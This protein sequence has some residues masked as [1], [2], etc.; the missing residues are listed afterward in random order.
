[1][2]N[3]HTKLYVNVT[4]ST[5]TSCFR[6]VQIE[7]V[8]QQILLNYLISSLPHNILDWFKLEV[9]A[10]KKVS[11]SEEQKIVLGRVENIVGKGENA[12]YLHFL[13][14]ALYFRK[15]SFSGSLKVDCVVKD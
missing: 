12:F 13:L 8:C 1:M 10:D 4:F 6:L 14:C 3:H 15:T 9:F 5:N 2:K 7:S 11:A